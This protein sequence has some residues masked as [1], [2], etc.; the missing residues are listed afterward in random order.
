LWAQQTEDCI[1]SNTKSY[2]QEN[3]SNF[4]DSIDNYRFFIMG[5]YHFR[6][7][8]TELFMGVFKDLYENANV[9]II[10]MESGYT[11]SLIINHYLQTDN[12]ES[13]EMLGSNNQFDKKL[14]VKLKEFYDT[15]PDDEK[16]R[17]IG[18]DLEIYEADINFSY[19]VNLMINDSTMPDKLNEIIEDFSDFA[20][21]KDL[22]K[23]QESFD[24]I[25]FDWKNN[26]NYYKDLMGG[27]Y[28]EYEKLL[29]KM[30]KSYRFDYYN[31]NYGRDSI[32]QTRRE[33]YI[34][35]NIVNEVKANPK[36]N[37]FGQFGLA[38]IGLNRFLIVNEK[39]GFQSFTAKL[40]N[41]PESPLNHKICSIAILYFDK[42]EDETSKL[43]HYY[44]ELAYSISRKKYLSNKIYKTLKNNTEYNN[45][46][47]VNLTKQCCPQCK[48]A[49]KN[50]Q[51]IIFKR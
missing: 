21:G 49:N 47:W 33:R 15:L 2:S 29:K 9:R 39:N 41:S 31:Y 12:S 32:K 23:T 24:N 50:F 43:V 25:Y 46:Y 26:K 18:V 30:K 37:Y 20:K 42:Y 13:F 3:D 34:Y 36:C 17:F 27:N 8:N 10:F 6:E 44:S 1:I 48:K 28:E 51:Y 22:D 19:V 40:N 35:N 11:N 38:H 5:E 16:F 7:E 45:T 14:Y 4:I